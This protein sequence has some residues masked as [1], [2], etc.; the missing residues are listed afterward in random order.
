MLFMLVSKLMLFGRCVPL[1]G[2]AYGRT[3]RKRFAIATGKHPSEGS[4]TTNLNGIF[5]SIIRMSINYW[6]YLTCDSN[7]VC[8]QVHQAENED[9]SRCSM[10]VLLLL[11]HMLVPYLH[12]LASPANIHNPNFLTRVIFAYELSSSFVDCMVMRIPSRNVADP[13][14]AGGSCGDPSLLL[15]QLIDPVS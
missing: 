3:V 15:N 7:D 2:T 10:S 5:R 12:S 11:I 13:K 14:K 1:L 4:S 6:S 9:G 8:A